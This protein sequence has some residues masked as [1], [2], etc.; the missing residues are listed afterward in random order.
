MSNTEKLSQEMNREFAKFLQ[1][2]GYSH[3]KIANFLEI[4][5]DTVAELLEEPINWGFNCLTQ[6]VH[7]GRPEALWNIPLNYAA[8]KLFDKDT[9]K[10][11]VISRIY[12]DAM[13]YVGT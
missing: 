6:G 11:I 12:N 1:T 13:Q 10:E 8:T 9:L 5:E 7:H 2:K 3:S 4:D